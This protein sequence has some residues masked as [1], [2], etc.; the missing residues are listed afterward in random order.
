MSYEG[1]IIDRYNINFKEEEKVKCPG[2]SK[3]VSDNSY[4]CPECGKFLQK[5]MVTNSELIKTYE[6]KMLQAI[7]EIEKKKHLK[8]AWDVTVDKYVRMMEKMQTI[9]SMPEFIS[10]TQKALINRTKIFMDRC[11]KPEF[12]IAFVGTIKAGKSTLI[13]ALLGKNYASTSVTP[14]TAVLTKFRH[15]E[16]ENYVKVEFY[17][18]TEWDLLWDSI[19]NNA[20]VFKEE[21]KKLQAENVK[22]QWIGHRQEYIR[23][24]VDELEDVI[25][26]W[27]SSKKAEHYFVKEVEIGLQGF[28]MPEEVVFVDTPGLDDA[29]K[30][31]SDVT[32]QYID[33]ANAVFACVKSDALTGQELNTLYRIFSNTSYNPEKVYVIGTQWDLLNNP[34]KDWELQKEEWAKYLKRKDAYGS[35]Q[36]AEKNITYA[37]AYLN[38]LARDYEELNEDENFTLQSMG[39]KFRIKPS[40][41]ESKLPDLMELSNIDEIR[42]HINQELITQYKEYLYKD[43]QELYMDIKKDLKVY[44]EDIKKSQE[45][46][47]DTAMKDIS[48][49]REDYEKAKKDLE[50]VQKYKEQLQNTLKIVR[51]DTKKRV[52]ALK[53]KLKELV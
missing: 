47:M 10:D 41:L 45:S 40:D 46:I 3:E 36:L 51:E 18:K 25:E 33:R 1:Y 2:C 24:S 32:R 35:E 37:A 53:D 39:F 9:L 28:H 5:G 30:Y 11:E 8:I 6:E 43:I 49:I 27:T 14:E 50:Q 13:N 29:V 42:R 20:D 34:K 26:R 44:F 4:F 7:K 12:H 16:K 15:C 31:R 21:Y 22:D 52:N 17:S 48:G 23:V 19:S 38:N